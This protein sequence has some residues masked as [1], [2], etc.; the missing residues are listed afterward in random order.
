[1]DNSIGVQ[2]SAVRNMFRTGSEMSVGA[3]AN[4]YGGKFWNSRPLICYNI[5][6]HFALTF[7]DEHWKKDASCPAVHP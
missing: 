2:R 3:S 4:E 7:V 6:E 1:M 5:E